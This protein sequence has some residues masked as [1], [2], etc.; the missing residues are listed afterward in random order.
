VRCTV[1]FKGTIVVLNTLARCD[2]CLAEAVVSDAGVVDPRP[3][4]KKQRADEMKYQF[5]FYE[6]V[7][8]GLYTGRRDAHD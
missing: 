4:Q 6:E 3:K 2:R 1:C 8:H 7:A 5:A